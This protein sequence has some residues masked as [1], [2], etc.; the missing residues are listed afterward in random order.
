MLAWSKEGFWGTKGDGSF[1]GKCDLLD[2]MEDIMGL[3]ALLG[4]TGNPC[5]YV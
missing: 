5:G 1:E 3:F 4:L 2:K